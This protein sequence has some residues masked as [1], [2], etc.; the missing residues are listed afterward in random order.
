MWAG[1][2]EREFALAPAAAIPNGKVCFDIGG[3]KGYMSGVMVLNGA[4][5]VHVFEPLPA[6]Q[7]SIRRLCDLI[8]NEDPVT[9]M[10]GWSLERNHAAERDA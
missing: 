3:Y 5:S 4:S 6:N 10:C 7:E 9:F 2:F 1:L 8:P